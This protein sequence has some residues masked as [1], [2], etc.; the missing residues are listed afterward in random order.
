MADHIDLPER[1]D[2]EHTHEWLTRFTDDQLAAYRAH[3]VTER[4][5]FV[6]VTPPTSIY[7]S[8][9]Y[10]SYRYGKWI[11]LVDDELANRD[12]AVQAARAA[13]MEAMEHDH[14]RFAQWVAEDLTSNRMRGLWAEWLLTD[15]LGLLQEG[16]GRI[17]WDHADIRLGSTTIEVKTTG[18][19]Q[20]WSDL[21][22]T[23]RFFI[24]PQTFTWDATTNTSARL[25]PP[26]RT[27]S[28]YVFCLHSCNELTNSAVT[29]ENNWQ[30]WVVPTALLDERFPKQK[31]LGLAGLRQ[32]GIAC[33]LDAALSQIREFAATRNSAADR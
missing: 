29:D 27:A 18:T 10:R 28:L 13:K 6:D 33:R 15:R 22:S 7:R 1:G 25:D 8:A 5:S 26:R 24:A 31:T 20:Q 2:F 14:S 23:P 12:P 9:S 17:E 4:A 3:L 32:F 11:Q 30:F 16:S 21:A 19:R